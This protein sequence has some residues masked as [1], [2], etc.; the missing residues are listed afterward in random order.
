LELARETFCVRRESRLN[1]QIEKL[2]VR[3]TPNGYD[4]HYKLE[5]QKA[6]FLFWTQAVLPSEK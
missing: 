4:S 1:I 6:V 3:P 2:Q 5:E